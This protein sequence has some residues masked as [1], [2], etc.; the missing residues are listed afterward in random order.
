[1]AV[2]GDTLE[3]KNHE[4]SINDKRL[5]RR[6]LPASVL[7]NIKTEIYGWQLEGDVYEETNDGAK[8]KIFITPESHEKAVNF[9]KITVPKHHCFI[10]GDFRSQSLDSRRFGPVP[11]ATIIGRADYLYWPGKDWSRIGKLD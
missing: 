9:E 1:M 10:L 8:Y 4:L 2:G 11:L 6:K 5:E 7:D 3:I